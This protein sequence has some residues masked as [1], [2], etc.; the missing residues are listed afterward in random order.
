MP[1]LI[2]AINII[3]DISSDTST[4]GGNGGSSGDSSNNSQRSG[5]IID[6]STRYNLE[7]VV[8]ELIGRKS[9]FRQLIIKNQ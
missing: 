9:I 8:E 1:K 6:A 4:S 3:G 7:N 5:G 2:R